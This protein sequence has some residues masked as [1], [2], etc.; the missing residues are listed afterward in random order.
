MLDIAIIAGIVFYIAYIWNRAKKEQS[1]A[2][3]G[4]NVIRHFTDSIPTTL[5]FITI[6]MLLAEAFIAASIH[7]TDELYVEGSGRKIN[8]FVISLIG[9]IGIFG[10]FRYTKSFKDPDTNNWVVAG[11][12]LVMLSIAIM[13]PIAN[14]YLIAHG[15]GDPSLPAELFRYWTSN[16][17]DWM[18]Y[19]DFMGYNLDYKPIEKS[20][21]LLLA[22]IVGNI[23]TVL[24]LIAEALIS[25]LK[26]A[27]KKASN[28]SNS[29]AGSTSNSTAGSGGA[30]SS[31]SNAP[32]VVRVAKEYVTGSHLRDRGE[33][34]LRE[35]IIKLLLD[36]ADKAILDSKD[37]KSDAYWDVFDRV[38][39]I[40]SQ[41]I[42]KKVEAGNTA[43]ASKL[44]TKLQ[45]LATK[46]LNPD[47]NPTIKA[48]VIKFLTD[49]LEPSN[50]TAPNVG[51]GFTKDELKEF[52]LVID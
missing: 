41:M 5:V 6:L 47:N 8:H 14:I 50:P 24:L 12:V 21:T 23:F 43:A 40:I 42:T 34:K 16:V 49:K 7:P 35:N 46:A 38:S 32:P 9:V 4:E 10:T 25:M 11:V 52:K 18:D 17:S 36:P 45:A 44:T 48:D 37:E 28:A 31:T 26:S 2:T 29:G 13:V 15:L 30:G 20:S 22:V 51:L 27:K 39:E 3:L 1:N 19:C 33:N